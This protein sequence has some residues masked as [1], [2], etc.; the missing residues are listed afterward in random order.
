MSI[1]AS[2]QSVWFLSSSMTRET[3][4]SSHSLSTLVSGEPRYLRAYVSESREA[5]LHRTIASCPYVNTA[6]YIRPLQWVIIQ[7]SDKFSCSSDKE[8]YSVLTFFFL[9]IYCLYV[10]IFLCNS[11]FFAN[12]AGVWPKKKKKKNHCSAL[13]N[14][15]L[16]Y[17]SPSKLLLQK[18]VG[19][20]FLGLQRRGW[21]GEEWGEF[22]AHCDCSLIEWAWFLNP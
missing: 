12:L 10:R 8:T 13:N 5:G 6:A 3:A 15:V 20:G 19:K 11:S 18:E 17:L 7:Y 14:N 2:Q 21:R 1:S 16:F 9:M 4:L 22:V